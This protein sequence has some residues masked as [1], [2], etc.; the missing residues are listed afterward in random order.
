MHAVDVERHPFF[1]ALATE[2]LVPR[3]K[4]LAETDREW[5]QR[6]ERH[7]ANADRARA[8][9]PLREQLLSMN[10][11]DAIHHSHGAYSVGLFKFDGP[12][13]YLDVAARAGWKA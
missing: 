1:V 9:L 7:H 5:Q 6:Y 2:Q 11:S 8:Q 10:T 13:G 4:Q 12:D 3:E